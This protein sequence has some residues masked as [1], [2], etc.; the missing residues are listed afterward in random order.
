MGVTTLV[1]LVLL[2]RM[3]RHE[4]TPIGVLKAFGYSDASVAAHYVRFAL[5]LGLA[6]CVAGYFGGEFVVR[7][8]MQIYV[9]VFQ[10]P[11]FR[12]EVYPVI[13]LKATA[14]TAVCATAGAV[15]AARQ[16]LRIQPA[17]A[18]RAEAPAHG[19]RIFLERVGAIWGRLS[20]SSK[21]IS[22]NLAR[23]RFRAVFTLSG[24]ALSTAMLLLGWFLMDAVDYMID[25]QFSQ[26]QL[27]D[28]RVLLN[29]EQGKDTLYDL[30]RMDDVKIAEPLLQYPFE[31]RSRWHKKDIS[32]AGLP[33]D[34]S[35]SRLIDTEGRRV[36][37]DNHGFMLD[38]RLATQL[39]V[40]P[41]DVLTLKPLMGRVPKETR[42]TVTKI[43][44]QYL[45]MGGYMEIGALSRILD[46][47]FAMNTVLIRTEWERSRELDKHLRDI[48]AIASVRIKEDSHANL[49]ASLA[50]SMRAV[51][52]IILGFAAAI[53]FAIIYN[54]TIVSLTERHRE[55][56][57]LRIMGFLPGEVGRLVYNENLLLSIIGLVAGMPLGIGL[58]RLIVMA[59]DNDLFRLPFKIGIRAYVLTV[60]TTFCF[61]TVA[62]LAVRRKILQLDMVEALKLRD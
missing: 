41:G 32:V 9:R 52:V 44:K 58:C 21:M 26:T 7:W 36:Q 45:G 17:L 54:S 20:F 1:L 29:G 15:S 49:K 30:Q 10:F 13:L 48:A 5:A 31:A 6:G 43:L 25:F 16:A 37:I 42:V 34:S 23:Y 57:A 14:L 4:R 60:I 3:V 50:E 59:Y 46:E 33:A 38:E 56:A 47:P 11:A 39:D 51:N 24:V 62:N 2:N 18:V 12:M 8:V 55:L 22:R 40:Q 53:A 61:V 28:V 19:R 35:L 27:E